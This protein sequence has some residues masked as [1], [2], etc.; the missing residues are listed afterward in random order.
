[1]DALSKIFDDIHLNHSEYIY[2]QAQGDWSFQSPAQDSVIAHI[3]LYGDAYLEITPQMQ[4]E[5]HTGDMF[6]IPAG[7]A[8]SVKNHPNTQLVESLN[9]APLFDG[10]RQDAI[11]FGHS[12]LNG[13][14]QKTLI[15]SVRCQMNAIM[16][17]PLINALPPYLHLQ[18]ALSDDA[19]EWLRIGLYFVSAETRRSMAGKNKIMDHVVSILMIECVRDYIEQMQHQNNWLNALIH[20]E[21]S[22]ALAAIHSRPEHNWTVESLAETCCMSRSKFANLFN[23]I[24]G[25]TP[26][27]YLQQHRLRLASQLLKQGQL[28]IQQIAHQVGYSSETAFSQA[29]KKQFELSPSQYRNQK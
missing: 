10:L 27:A 18:N 20:P 24:I 17:R 11:E 26:L 7:I 15:L 1:M 6:L 5:L 23:Q 25:E 4:V 29:F 13:D 3:V 22:N 21:L 9:I 14:N 16:A 8:H 12:R 19:P 28:S 2:L